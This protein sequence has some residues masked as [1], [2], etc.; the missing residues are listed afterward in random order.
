MAL[1]KSLFWEKRLVNQQLKHA[2]SSVAETSPTDS[3]LVRPILLGHNDFIHTSRE[4]ASQHLG[5]FVGKYSDWR[6]QGL[7]WKLYKPWYL[8]QREIGRMEALERLWN[9]QSVRFQQMRV[10]TV[11]PH[12]NELEMLAPSGVAPQGKNAQSSQVPANPKGWEI[13]KGNPTTINS[14][15]EL[16]LFTTIYV[17][18][19]K[20]PR[21]TI[22]RGNREESKNNNK[23]P[24]INE[25]IM[26]A[27][28]ISDLTKR[29]LESG[30][31]FFSDENMVS[32][33]FF[34][35]LRRQVSFWGP[36]SLVAAYAL[37]SSSVMNLAGMEPY[38]FLPPD[39]SQ[40]FSNFFLQVPKV[41]DKLP[42]VRIIDSSAGICASALSVFVPIRSLWLSLTTSLGFQLTAYET[43]CRI[44]RG[45]PTVFQEVQMHTLRVPFLTTLSW[46][47][48]YRPGDK[49][50]NS[51]ELTRFHSMHLMKAD[52][53]KE[54]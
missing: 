15:A 45:E 17:E 43:F 32:R 27:N 44:A 31:D 2:R 36:L 26:I 12:L 23:E 18:A 16:K 24:I 20:L 21:L 40:E 48:K 41:D 11:T 19:L 33:R 47:T 1:K 39:L 25:Q 10:V 52:D 34:Y 51:E 54:M 13:R 5:L 4:E 14:F 29:K 46:F 37:A 38:F 49:I 42:D 8:I 9:N 3:G 30:L 22:S 53:L 6:M 7:P 35:Y 28:Q 50:T